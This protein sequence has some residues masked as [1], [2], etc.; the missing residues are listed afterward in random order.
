MR[1]IPLQFPGFGVIDV[2]PRAI[3]GK[4]MNTCDDLHHRF[5][6][7]HCN[8]HQRPQRLARAESFAPSGDQ[9]MALIPSVCGSIRLSP[10]AMSFKGIVAKTRE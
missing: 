8:C 3:A 6:R 9:E 1:R 5:R 2:I 4:E 10:V 7:S